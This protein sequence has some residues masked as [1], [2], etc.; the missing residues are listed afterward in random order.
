MLDLA[1]ETCSPI[2]IPFVVLATQR[3]LSYKMELMM[4]AL[5]GSLTSV[6]TKLNNGYEVF[7]KYTNAMQIHD[8]WLHL[9]I[10]KM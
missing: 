2:R 4:L 3:E 10:Q 7:W 5:P 1:L 6:K 9:S 8:T